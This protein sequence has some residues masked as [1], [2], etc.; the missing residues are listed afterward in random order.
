M[1]CASWECVREEYT[2]VGSE[3]SLPPPPPPPLSPPAP[4]V[5]ACARVFVCVCV[6]LCVCMRVCVCASMILFGSV[7][8]NHSG[9]VP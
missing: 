3:G 7:S 5:C 6:C 2:T 9:T 8:N 1:T 4:V